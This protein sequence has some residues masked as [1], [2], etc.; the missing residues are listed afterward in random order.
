M[1]VLNESEGTAYTLEQ[2]TAYLNLLRS[3]DGLKFYLFNHTI[4]E[5]TRT[6]LYNSFDYGHKVKDKDKA[7]ALDKEGME[8][9]QGVA[10]DYV[11]L[12]D[13]DD[14]AGAVE[15]RDEF[16]AEEWALVNQFLPEAVKA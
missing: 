15:M 5:S 11:A 4:E 1:M 16:T 13:S 2:Q 8:A 12:L 9:I 10:L 3:G 6:A 14:T 7:D